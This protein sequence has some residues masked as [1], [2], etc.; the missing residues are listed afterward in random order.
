MIIYI[1]EAG[2]FSNPNKKPNYISCVGGL[3]IP[4]TCIDRIFDE[5]KR[6]KKS[7]NLESAEIK[8]SSLDEKMVDQVIS[9][10][11]KED[12]VFKAI[13]ID[14]GFQEDNVVEKS[15]LD[16][17]SRLRKSAIGAKPKIAE[18]L[19]DLADTTERLSNQLY[20]QS[21]LLIHLV[22]RLLRII[23]LYYSQRNPHTLSSFNWVFDAKNGDSITPY[24]NLWKAVCKPYLQT[25]SLAHPLLRLKGADYSCFEKFCGSTECPPSHLVKHVNNEKGKQFQT[26]DL[27]LLMENIFFS[28]SNDDLGL[29][30]IDIL[31]TSLR[32]AFSKTL[33]IEGWKNI[34]KIM[35]QPMKGNL[36]VDFVSLV[37]VGTKKTPYGGMLKIIEEQSKPMI[38]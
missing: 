35:V 24:E 12:V 6:L 14:L 1:D 10:L 15:K 19:A 3:A 20:T 21:V 38:K 36:I 29:Q 31:V 27:N 11:A 13:S 28:E 32:R 2:I 26:I 22:D 9:L 37:E 23:T 33:Q 17:G 5:F 18:H 25:V 30:L 34:G 4:E 7:W 8:G 16:Q